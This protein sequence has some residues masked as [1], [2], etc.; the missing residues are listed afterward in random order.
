[1]Q[2]RTAKLPADDGNEAATIGH[3][4]RRLRTNRGLTLQ[5]LSAAS[6]VA[7]GLLSQIERGISSPS[8]RTLT[9]IRAALDV[10]I[11]VF[12][13]PPAQVARAEAKFIRRFENR[14][15]VD[16]GDMRLVKE[17]LSP[18][19]ASALQMMMLVIPPGGGAGAETYSYEGEKAGVVLEGFFKLHIAGEVYDL[20]KNDSFQFDSSLPHTF[21]NPRST[22]ARVLWIVCKPTAPPTL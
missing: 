5:A 3:Q 21:E 22:E 15:T 2:Q 6:G 14:G 9:K 13:A 20:R 7:V 12:F 11:G 8:L 17:L 1:M 18:S 10:P 4:V 19:P 16:L